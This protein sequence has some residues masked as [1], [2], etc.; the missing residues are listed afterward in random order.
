MSLLCG[1]LFVLRFIKL[2]WPFPLRELPP[3]NS[4]TDDQPSW[5]VLQG[6][7]V[8]QNAANIVLIFKGRALPLRLICE[9]RIPYEADKFGHYT[10]LC[11]SPLADLQ[12][13][14]PMFRIFSLK[15]IS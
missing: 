8:D 3:S 13:D 10:N 14:E 9:I 12:A 11:A 15:Q 1:H 2:I 6:V 7:R 5:R 4:L